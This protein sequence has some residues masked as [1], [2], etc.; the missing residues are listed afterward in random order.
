[1]VELLA[2]PPE[3]MVLD[4]CCGMGNFVNWL[5]SRHN[6]YGFDVD[7]GAVNVAKFLYPDAN[8]EKCDIVQYNPEQRFD[9]VIGN[10]PFNLKFDGHL[11]QFYYMTKAHEVL[12]PAGFLMMIVPYSFLAVEFWEKAKVSAINRDFS[13]IGQ[14]GLPDDAFASLGVEKFATKIMVFMRES[15]HIGMKPYDAEEF[16]TW[17]QLRE[18]I[19]KAK[20]IKAGVRIQLLREATNIDTEELERFEYR[21][22][23]YI[24]EL[25]IHPRLRKHLDKAVALVIK[26]RNQKPPTNCTNEEYKRWEQTKLTPNEL[27][28]VISRYVRNQNVVP[29]KEVALVKT[30]YGF[31]LKAYAPKLLDKVPKKSAMINDLVLEFDELPTPEAPTAKQQKQIRLYYIYFLQ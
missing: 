10:P 1:M 27:L 17:E 26:F 29:R 30:N 12:N 15:Q 25:K 9:T 8:I 24:F 11:S 13:F 7:A 16:L 28:S 22:A 23:K 4:M 3:D 14:T 31:R 18:R 20:A 19:A 21:L 5:P 6:A 2:P